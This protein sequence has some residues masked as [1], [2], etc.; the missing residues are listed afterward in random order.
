[1]VRDLNSVCYCFGLALTTI[2]PAKRASTVLMVETFVFE[3]V[4]AEEVF[5]RFSLLLLTLYCH[6]FGQPGFEGGTG[7]SRALFESSS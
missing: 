5:L 1:M 3:A 7:N 6:L 4:S 2:E